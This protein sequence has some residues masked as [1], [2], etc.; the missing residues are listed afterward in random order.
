MIKWY[1][2]GLLTWLSNMF[3]KGLFTLSPCNTMKRE[4]NFKLLYIISRKESHFGRESMELEN[5]GKQYVHSHMEVG[6]R[7]Q[8]VLSDHR[9]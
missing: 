8:D 1:N 3:T 5:G 7:A 4:N 2:H 9:D 6:F